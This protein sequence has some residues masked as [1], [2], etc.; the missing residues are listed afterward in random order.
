[1]IRDYIAKNISYQLQDYINKTSILKTTDFLKK[2]QHWK[3]IDLESYQF[4]KFLSLLH[5]SV[6]NVPY[7]RSLFKEN[8]L[9]IADIKNP[10][11]IYKIPVLTKETARK[12]V[13]GL[14]A[15]NI[16]LKKTVSGITGG[17]TGP[18]LK[19][20]RDTQ[21]LSFTWGAFYRWYSWMGIKPGDRITKIWGT[22]TVLANTLSKRIH[23][24]LK[25]F[26]YNRQHINSFQLNEHS[27]INVVERINK[28]K[29]DL[30]RGYL[31]ALIQVGEFIQDNNIEIHGPKAISSTTETLFP[32]IKSF[33]KNAFRTE[34]YDQY[35]CGE[36]NSIAFDNNDGNGLYIALEHVYLE[37]LGNDQL[38]LESG[39]GRIIITNL[40]NYLMPFIRYENGDIANFGSKK[41]PSDIN[42]PVLEKISGRIADTIILKDGS[43]VHGVFFTDILNDLYDKRIEDF[44]RFQVYQKEPGKIEFR[45]EVKQSVD[46]ELIAKLH[47]GLVQFFEDVAITSYHELPKDKSGKF[48][49]IISDLHKK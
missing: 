21:D 22:P 13:N 18:P 38:N 20:L 43:K 6:K 24:S 5:H 2:T 33:L 41:Y 15:E 48:R 4:E 40:D 39:D 34:I 10:V 27:L 47:D 9:S 1:M 12:N 29:P 45:I 17:T 16:D 46:S 19:I 26:Y 36:C 37:I 3:Q 7:Y 25:N 23:S 30:I 42:L 14:R 11:D 8:S 28:F 32:A 49:Y 31:S 44:N 35:G